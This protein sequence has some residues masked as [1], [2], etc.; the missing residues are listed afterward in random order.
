MTV[1]SE[2]RLTKQMQFIVEI[3]KLKRVIRQSY[4]LD[5]SRKENDAE[6]SWHFALMAVI[7]QEYANEPLDVGRVIQMALVHDLVEIDAGDTFMY[8]Q[9]GALTK[10]Q[11]ERDAADRIFQ[12]LPQD[13]AA[14]LRELWEEFE[15]RQTPEARFAATIDRLEPILLNYH[16]K[17]RSWL[18]HN[19]KMEDAL[20]RNRHM[21][22][23]SVSLWGYVRQ[24]FQ[25]GK[26]KGYWPASHSGQSQQP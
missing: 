10:A 2:D 8:D 6:H 9:A 11:R 15:A 1:P 14:E 12:L 25:D 22:E 23:G 26:D 19:V 17:G 16:N 4:H 20:H 21:A 24:L 13:Q 7:L 3:E 5:G 18:E